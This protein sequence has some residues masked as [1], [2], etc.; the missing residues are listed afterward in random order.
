[1]AQGKAEIRKWSQEAYG[2]SME[3]FLATLP[4][5]KSR[6]IRRGMETGAWLSVLPST[7]SGPELLAQ[8]F[9]DALSMCYRE[10][11]PGLPAC[12]DG[13]DAPFTLQHALACKKGGLV[14]FHHNEI[15]DE[16]VNLAGKAF[17]PSAV[18]DEPLIKPSHHAT[19]NAK[20]TPTKDA[21]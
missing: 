21:S 13:R 15:R 3:T 9:R 12:C 17:T 5:G 2:K 7:V 20:D 1:M 11:P 6:T 10:A 8:D 14:I 18:R 16:L 4:T 19:E